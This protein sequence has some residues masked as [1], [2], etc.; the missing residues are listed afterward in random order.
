VLVVLVVAHEV[1]RRRDWISGAGW[2]TVALIASLSW[3]MPWYVIWLLPLAALA[4]GIRL[5]RTALA[6]TV[7]LILSFM[8]VTQLYMSS[9]GIRPLGGAAGQASLSYQNKLEK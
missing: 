1:Y 2:S 8:P 3:L 5:R 4:T 9:H 6:L 7:F